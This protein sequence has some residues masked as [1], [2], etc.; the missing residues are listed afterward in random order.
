MTGQPRAGYRFFQGLAHRLGANRVDQAQDN[1]FVS[2]QPQRSVTPTE[3][4]LA[5]SQFDQLLLDVSFD[6]D[7]LRPRWPRP[8]VESRFDSLGDEPLPDTNDCP[9]ACAQSGQNVLVTVSVAMG[10]IRKKQN[11]GVSELATRRPPR[12]D[13]T[14]QRNALIHLQ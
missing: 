9:R 8:G 5:A 12:G 7:L 3:G 10:G 11:A 6:L 4:W 14:F 1:H 2:E 13:Q